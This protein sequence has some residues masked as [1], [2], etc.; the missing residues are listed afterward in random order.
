MCA[1]INGNN[2]ASKSEIIAQVGN[3]SASTS[4]IIVQV[5]L[6]KHS[7]INVGRAYRYKIV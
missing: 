3:N 7:F 2:S 5:S 1:N 4:E 6:K